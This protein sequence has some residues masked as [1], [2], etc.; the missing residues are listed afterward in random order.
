MEEPIN[1]IV[2]FNRHA[3]QQAQLEILWYIVI[4]DVA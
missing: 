2:W 1:E 3:N 4:L